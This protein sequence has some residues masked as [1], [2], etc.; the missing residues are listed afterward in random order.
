MN[1]ADARAAISVGDPAAEMYWP[2]EAFG[3]N[4]SYPTFDVSTMLTPAVLAR[5]TDITSK[6]CWYYA[7]AAAREMAPK[8]AAL[9]DWER[10]PE[11]RRFDADSRS[12]D[13]PIKGPLMVLAGDDD[14]AVPIAD[15]KAGVEEACRVGLPIEFL[16]RPGP[17]HQALM[18]STIDQQLDWAR[19][20]LAG[21][22]WNA[23]RCG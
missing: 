19:D 16:H 3:I 7:Y 22:P 14:R 9:R 18:H 10:A 21:K 15:V 12:G 13:K 2:L 4:A 5:Y 6:G 20:R 11:V 23:E 1:F 17:D 8:P